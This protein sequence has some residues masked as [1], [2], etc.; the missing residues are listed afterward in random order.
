MRSGRPPNGAGVASDQH[1][2]GC[3]LSVVT[4]PRRSS[5]NSGAGPTIKQAQL[6][7]L[8]RQLR[9]DAQMTLKDAAQGLDMSASTI[10]RIERGE[11]GIPAD[12]VQTMTDL[13]DRPPTVDNVT[14]P[15]LFA[16]LRENRRYEE[17][18][19]TAR[20]VWDVQ[21]TTIPTLLQTGAYARE[22][23]KASMVP[24]SPRE[25]RM[26]LAMRMV[27]QRR[28]KDAERPLSL[29]AVVHEM[30]LRW[31]VGDEISRRAQLEHLVKCAEL[32]SVSLR[33][34]PADLGPSIA[35]DGAFTIL[36]FDDG[37]PDIGYLENSWGAMHVQQS[38]QVEA[39]KLCFETL[40]EQ[41]LDRE[42]SMTLIKTIA[43]EL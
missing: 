1:L 6:G 2:R 39:C 22:V 7:R 15:E 31:P 41:A 16:G 8:L 21:I 35:M 33:V 29:E 24:R 27:R 17:L 28:L 23:L 11:S 13:Y 5:M 32:D 30:A 26:Q 19:A 34:L 14:N 18:E 20:R 9:N 25:H 3:T 12:L 4:Q 43:N 36:R 42:D 40:S 10:G 37:R 38:W